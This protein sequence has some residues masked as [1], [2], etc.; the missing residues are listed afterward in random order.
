MKRLQASTQGIVLVVMAMACFAVLD[1][2]AKY[3]STLVPLAVAMWSRYAFQAV[4][5]GAV[6]LPR[7]GWGLL[8]TRHPWLQVLRGVLLAATSSLAF[9]SLRSL[10]VGEFT[11]LLM[12]T[13]MLITVISAASM[14]EK[15]SPLRWL[16][17][18]GGFIGALIVIRPGSH[19]FDWAML[20]PL[21]LVLISAF[22]QLLTSR[23]A[24]DD[25]PGTMHFYTG[26]VAMVLASVALPFAWETPATPALWALLLMLGVFSTLGHYLL[27]LGYGRATPSTLTPFLYFQIGF[28]ALAGWIAFS[29]VPDGWAV[30]GIGLIA[31]CGMTSSWLPVPPRAVAPT[32]PEH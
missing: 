21:A 4:L 5:T 9:I 24:Q 25:D 19:G 14:G 7:R 30:L 3:I 26:A 22:F 28:A 8:K 13:P 31:L 20:F 23:L 16:L 27:I 12:L 6:L 11:A 2:T 18:T 10:P 15:V 17:L 29:H 1:T 32:E